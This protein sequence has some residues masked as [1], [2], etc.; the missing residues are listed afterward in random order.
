[1]LVMHASGIGP[2]K[3]E[4]WRVIWSVVSS[5]KGTLWD[6]RN[7][8]VMKREVLKS[9]SGVED[10]IQVCCGLLPSGHQEEGP[11]L[12]GSLS[13]LELCHLLAWGF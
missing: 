10:G 8:F 9:S 4:Q 5:I 3:P 13:H 1:M 7:I 2:W 6:A 12:G 11:A